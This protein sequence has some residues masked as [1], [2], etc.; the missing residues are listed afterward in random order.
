[1]MTGSLSGDTVKNPKLNVNSTSLASSACS[2][3]IED[4]QHKY[5]KSLKL[6][7]NGSAFIQGEMPKK[8]K[9][10]GLFTLPCRLGDS[11]P[12]NTLADLG[13]CVN[14]IPL[15]L[16][17]TLNVR[18]LE[19]TKN[20]LGLADGTGSYLVGIVKNVD[21]H[22]E[23]KLLEGFYAIDM[24]KDPTCPLLV[25]SGFLATASAIIDCKKAKIAVGERVTRSV[26]G[27]KENGL[28]HAQ[29]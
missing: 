19:E 20:V 25:G 10:P 4:P 8:M 29:F 18:I 24:E 13:S 16:F 5:V 6:G 12:F 3:P 9:D 28:G 7:K 17:K 14:L 21:T 27:V 22:R 26:F 2:Y 15:Y 23:D 11:K 1:M